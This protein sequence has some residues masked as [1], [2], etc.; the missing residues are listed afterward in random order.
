[1]KKTKIRLEDKE[2]EK[3][4]GDEDEDIQYSEKE[5]SQ[6]SKNLTNRERQMETLTHEKESRKPKK[7][8]DF[9]MNPQEINEHQ[10]IIMAEKFFKTADFQS[11]SLTQSKKFLAIHK[12][13][14]E[15]KR[16][17]CDEISILRLSRKLNRL[18]DTIIDQ[19]REELAIEDERKKYKLHIETTFISRISYSPYKVY[20]A[21][22]NKNEILG[23]VL[24]RNMENMRKGLT[25]LY[26]HPC[27][28]IEII[29]NHLLL[30]DEVYSIVTELYAFDSPIRMNYLPS[31][32][33]AALKR[34][35]E[36]VDNFD[37][38]DLHCLPSLE[39]E[40]KKL[41]AK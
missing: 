21:Y 3:K 23:M 37:N 28:L 27:Y 40:E 7:L 17:N 15:E 18:L 22:R 32:A 34:D 16:H 9:I 25:C 10:D 11:I 35:I 5:Y 12:F 31:L 1:M 26:L 6:D 4:Y 38:L 24:A 29:E 33:L 2:E 14:L 36:N 30:N 19:I 20:N 13:L 8:K 39:E 41:E